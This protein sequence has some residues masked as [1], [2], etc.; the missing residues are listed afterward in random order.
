MV[1]DHIAWAF[2]PVNSVP[3]FFMHLIG[4]TTGPTMAFFL[5]EGFY[6][7][8]NIKAYAYRLGIFSLVSWPAFTLFEFGKLPL[9]YENGHLHVI[10]HFPVLFT[11]LLS[12]IA[13]WVW[14][15]SNYSKNLR[16]IVVLCLAFLT[17]S[18]DWG[19]LD[20]MFAF[21]FYENREDKKKLIKGYLIFCLIFA[22]LSLLGGGQF[23]FDLS[24]FGVLLVAPL[25]Y[26]YNGKKGSDKPVH[27]WFFYVFYPL[28]LLIIWGIGLS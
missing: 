2:V 10:Y 8:K 5:A 3:S 28:H 20:M 11:L 21:Y 4:R 9:Y 26:L 15:K 19:V 1:I 16:Q 7:S 22:I 24:M 14:Y 13:L 23:W 27:K 12:L 18:S 6:Y 25:I 17:V